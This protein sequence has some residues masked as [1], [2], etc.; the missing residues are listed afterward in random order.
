MAKDANMKKYTKRASVFELINAGKCNLN[1]AYCYIPK[2]S[3]MNEM[4]N[5]IVKYLS[6]GIFIEDMHNTIGEDLQAV[7]L[8]GTEPTI[9]LDIFTS[10]LPELVERF[11]RLN[12]VGFS[13]NFISN[14]DS[15]VRL[16]EALPTGREF[17]LKVQYSLDGPAWITDETRGMPGATDKIVSN[18]MRFYSDLVKI[19]LRD[20]K[21]I[22]NCKVTWDAP[23]IEMLASDLSKITE[24]Y[25]FFNDL[26]SRIIAIVER[27]DTGV[28]WCPRFDFAVDNI[29]VG[30]GA[31][32]TLGLP[33][34]YTVE[35]GKRLGKVFHEVRRIYNTERDKY[36]YIYGGY[37]KYVLDLCQL[38][39][40]REEYFENPSMFTC[41][42]GDSE[43]GMDHKGHLHG[44]HRTFFMNDERYVQS[45]KKDSGR[46][47]W[48]KDNFD[49]GK[50]QAVLR[51]IT[52][53]CDDE[54]NKSRFAYIN[55]GF[56]H[57]G[58]QKQ[59][60]I[61]SMVKLMALAGQASKIYLDD[62][63]ATLFSHFVTK[64]FCCPMSDYVDHHNYRALSLGIIRV[65][66]NG[67]FEDMMDEVEKFKSPLECRHIVKHQRET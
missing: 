18:L 65:L 55:G 61:Y 8:W 33:G 37:N 20:K 26:N 31:C 23:I 21:I 41:A 32:L 43:Y 62:S 10:K 50:T 29:S 11:P 9:T 16:A 2:T 14:T 13:S 53:R 57:F 3:A 7:T 63:M 40:R 12:H 58:K 42:A 25:E 22:T 54:Y 46:Q 60:W 44:C 59:R 45:V 17:E 6:D 27:R 5:D 36:P 67:A 38:L 4:H 49:S 48:D 15:I 30:M 56:H 64:T 24:Y 1:C 28:P 47:N 39:D 52:A 35:D 66:A 34:Q 51:G 19:D